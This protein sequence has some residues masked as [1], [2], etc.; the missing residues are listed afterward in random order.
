MGNKFNYQEIFKYVVVFLLGLYVLGVLLALFG[1]P[2][3]TL[4]KSFSFLSGLSS[5]LV[6]DYSKIGKAPKSE[7]Q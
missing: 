4:Q 6:V 7:T 5:Y 1:L 3:G 2:P